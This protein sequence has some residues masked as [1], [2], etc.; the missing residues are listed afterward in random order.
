MQRFGSSFLRHTSKFRLALDHAHH[1][2]ETYV[3]R[4]KSL[5]AGLGIG[6]GLQHLFRV[7]LHEDMS[8]TPAR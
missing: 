8:R 5:G 4:A 1:L 6:L 3:R 7:T 2:P